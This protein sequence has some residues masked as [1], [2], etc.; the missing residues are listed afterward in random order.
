MLFDIC[1]YQHVGL[2][3]KLQNL[4]SSCY[5]TF[6]EMNLD[7]TLNKTVFKGESR[8]RGDHLS[9]L[10]PFSPDNVDLFECSLVVRDY[11]P[12]RLFGLDGWISNSFYVYSFSYG[13]LLR[14][15]PRA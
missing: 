1:I 5:S 12:P 10:L 4:F 7:Y 8:V 11:F 13:T 14:P 9:A 6:E 15:S 3:A 2:G